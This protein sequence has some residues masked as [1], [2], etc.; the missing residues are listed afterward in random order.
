MKAKS[1]TKIVIIQT[2]FIGDS[3]LTIPLLKRLRLL[4]PGASIELICRPGLKEFFVKT[5]LVDSAIEWDK[6]KNSVA[7]VI[8]QLKFSSYDLS[9]VPHQSFRSFLLSRRIKA[10]QRISF[11]RWWNFFSNAAVERDLDLPDALRQLSLLLPIDKVEL[12]KDLRLIKSSQANGG[13][14]QETVDF[15]ERFFLEKYSM[16]LGLLA[17]DLLEPLPEPLKTNGLHKYYLVA[18]GSVW[19]T[20]RW[21]DDS[22]LVLI[23]NIIREGHWVILSGSKNESELCDRLAEKVAS[24][25]LI[26]LCGRLSLYET[27]CVLKRIVEAAITND[28][29]TMHLAAAAGVRTISIFGP[30]TLDI[31]YRPWQRNAVVVQTPLPCRPCGK[32]GHQ[33]CPIGTHDCMKKIGPEMVFNELKF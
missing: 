18:P 17:A 19:N 13:W 15:S 23:L 32:H 30:T 26:N 24:P 8:G 3:L 11:R 4:R 5:G 9:L 12:S 22:F 16:Q 20:K 7:S 29:G 6:K 14:G 21:T 25:H 2:A 33:N 10:R 28:S 1:P 31:G 27:F